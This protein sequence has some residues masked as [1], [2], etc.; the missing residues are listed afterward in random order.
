MV[1]PAV[2]LAGL[3]AACAGGPQ[4]TSP[5][6]PSSTAAG[7]P[8]AMGTPVRDGGLEFVVKGVRLG[9]SISSDHTSYTAHGRY[10]AI[11]LSVTNI[12]DQPASYKA[13]DR[14]L[15]VDGTRYDYA[16]APT[17]L[18]TG[19][20]TSQIVPGVGIDTLIAYDIPA[21]TRP[22]SIE[23]HGAPGTPGV[24]VELSLTSACDRKGR[25]RL[26][27]SAARMDDDHDP[28]R[29]LMSP[30]PGVPSASP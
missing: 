5:E 11:G 7:P 21:G 24:E 22:E 12:G 25:R 6:A 14:K 27:S 16:A 8:P 17:S 28:Q 23:L 30:V 29:A 2:V 3:L 15:N 19:N 1:W 9:P 10:A 4:A 20:A 26:T 18:L 13:V